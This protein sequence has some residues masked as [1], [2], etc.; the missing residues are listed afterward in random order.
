SALAEKGIGDKAPLSKAQSL[1]GF[2]WASLNQ[3]RWG[4]VRRP[5][6]KIGPRFEVA[7]FPLQD[8]ELSKGKM[9][10]GRSGVPR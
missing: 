3:L 7:I 9:A 2:E 8:T 4:G 6:Q 5:G 1:P 10:T